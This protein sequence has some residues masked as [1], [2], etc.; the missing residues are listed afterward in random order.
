MQIY[1]KPKQIERAELVR[2]I[3]EKRLEA[4][5][6]YAELADI[7]DVDASQVS[8]ICRGQFITFGASVVR[9]CTTLGLQNTQGEGTT[10]KRSRRAFDPN[11]AKLERSIRRAWDNTPVGA[12]RLAK[13]I[14]AVGEITRK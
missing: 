12:E 10:W 1:M 6:S 3:N 13:V 9:I 11:W 4:G 2:H 5:L 7:A 8:R 14:G